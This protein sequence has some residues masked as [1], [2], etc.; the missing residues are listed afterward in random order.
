[1]LSSYLTNPQFNRENSIMTNRIG[2][3]G[4]TFD[5]PH[6]GHLILAENALEGFGL[7]RVLFVLN[8]DPPHKRS[9]KVTPVQHRL[10]MLTAAIAENPRFQLS[11]IEIDRPPPYYTYHTL[12]LLRDQFPNSELIFLMGGDS[13]RDL[14]NWNHPEIILTQVQIGVMQ[15]PGERIYM[16]ELV[17]RLPLLEGRVQ[18]MEAPEI[19]IA[20]RALRKTIARG[21]SVRYQVPDAVITYIQ[22]H[23]LYEE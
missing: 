12:Q 19:G 11:R 22:T 20:A 9:V 1:M 8:G 4:G 13:L 15:R 23:R 2:V 3:F 21:G 18:F 7:S 16:D 6:L 5:P 14:P 10:P 17:E